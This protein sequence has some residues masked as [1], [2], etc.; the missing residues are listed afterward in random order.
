VF[1]YKEY[2]V[3]LSETVLVTATG[4]ELLTNVEQKLLVVRP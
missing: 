3:G 4:Y 2:G 1:E